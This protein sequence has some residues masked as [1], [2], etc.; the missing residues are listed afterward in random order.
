MLSSA[1]IP[2]GTYLKSDLMPLCVLSKAPQVVKMKTHFLLGIQAAFLLIHSISAVV[3]AAA[4][5]T[6]VS[7]SVLVVSHTRLRQAA[8]LCCW[9]RFYSPGRAL[10]SH[11][12]SWNGHFKAACVPRVQCTVLGVHGNGTATQELLGTRFPLQTS[13]PQHSYSKAEEAGKI[14]ISMLQTCIHMYMQSASAL[15]TLG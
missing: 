8:W 1:F 4:A 3:M 13:A 9:G 14:K 5:K 7:V 2:R 6:T 15:P 12:G 11:R 10:C